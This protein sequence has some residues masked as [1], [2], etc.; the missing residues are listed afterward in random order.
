M[1]DMIDG[2]I[3]NSADVELEV[4]PVSTPVTSG[5]S[6]DLALA[7]ETIMH[8]RPLYNL[9]YRYYDGDHPL[10]YST[11]RLRDAFG[12]WDRNIRFIMNW[13][14]VVVDAVLDRLSLKG[15]DLQ[16]KTLDDLIDEA[17]NDNHLQLLA[18]EVHEAATVCGE[19]FVM[20]EKND[21][22]GVDVYFNDPRLCH[23][24]YDGDRPGVKK[25][26]AKLWL[27]LDGKDHLNLY[28]PERIEHYI[29]SGANS[30]AASA[31]RA[32]EPASEGN[33]YD[34]VP[35]FHFRSERRPGKLDL[36]TAVRSKQDAVNKLFSD[37][38]V[39]AEFSA[40]KQK[41]IISQADPGDLKTFENWWIP[42]GD[43]TGQQS[44]VIELGGAPLNNFL[45]A[46]DKVATAM[47]IITR[48]PKFYFFAQGG[49]PSGDALIAMEAPL[50]KKTKKRQ[51]AYAVTWCEVA[52]FLLKLMGKD[53][54]KESD[55]TPTWEPV[56]TVQPKSS[57]DI[58]KV[59]VDSTVPLV[60]ALRR[61]GWAKDEL[62]QL[63]KDQKDAKKAAAGVASAALDAARVASEQDP[64]TGGGPSGAASMPAG[65]VSAGPQ[66]GVMPAALAPGAAAAAAASGKA[67]G[68]GN[69]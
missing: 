46:I 44:N 3:V 33:T 69:G 20:A 24:F 2:V 18:D 39:A 23:V 6:G 8:K 49:D 25:F 45:D 68:S 51:E 56:E 40:L 42:A 59:L 58:V 19:A 50:V 7:F 57:A 1:A 35:V 15:F 27:G 37:M 22:G 52:V 41:A 62:E 60:T 26:A 9:L 38:M 29:A 34:E 47:A 28:Y 12:K 5:A 65:M 61:Q 14:G 10:K 43:G 48:T 21:E 64:N 30:G 67:A 17:W 54:V 4:P 11:K 13:T 66:K 36:N 63:A 32:D 53:D 16:D 31:F 55:I